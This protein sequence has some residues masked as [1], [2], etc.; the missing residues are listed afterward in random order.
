MKKIRTVL[1]LLI[2]LGFISTLV[3][4]VGDVFGNP[5]GVTDNFDN[6]NYIASKTNLVV[7]GGQVMLE[8]IVAVCDSGGVPQT[9]DWGSNLYGCSGVDKRCYSG[10]CITCGGWMN[11]G[12]CWYNGSAGQSCTT[13][14]AGQGGVYNGNCNW[15][16]DPTDCSTSRHWFP[17]GSCGG[18]S[19]RGPYAWIG[20]WPETLSYHRAGYSECDW[21]GGAN[22]TLVVRQCACNQ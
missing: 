20:T 16:N 14:C 18:S 3:G 4:G 6:E 21:G 15:A 8:E 1:S 9:T 10:S 2:V 22:P 17:S 13:I 19:R 5:D 12:Y 11:A 7:S